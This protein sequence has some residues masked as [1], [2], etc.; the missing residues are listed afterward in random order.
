M[1]VVAAIMVA[2]GAR[3]DVPR[4][5][6]GVGQWKHEP[7]GTLTS[8]STA[9]D[10]TQGFP[11]TT[12]QEAYGHLGVRLGGP[13]WAPGELWAPMLRLRYTRIG[14]SGTSFQD[15]STYLGGVLITLDTTDRRTEADFTQFEGLLYFTVGDA[16]RAELGGGIKR[17]DGSIETRQ[18]RTTG[19]GATT[20]SESREIP[21]EFPVWYGGLY[22]QPAAW[23]SF[24]AEAT[25]SARANDDVRDYVAR[26]VLRP[27]TWMGVEG[28]YRILDMDVRDAAGTNYEFEFR[29]SYAGLNFFYGTPAAPVEPEPAPAPPPPPPADTDGDGVADGVDQCPRTP[30]GAAVDARGCPLDADGDTVPDGV[31]QCPDTPANTRVGPDGCALPAPAA[32]PPPDEDGDGVPDDLDRCP[33][34]LPG[35]KVNMSG[36]ATRAQATVLQGV[37][38]QLN[39]SYLMRDS[40]VLLMKVVEAL[41]AQPGLKVLIEGHTC[42]IGDAKY[43][44]WLSQRRANRV[45]EFLVRHGIPASRL[46]AQGFGEEKPVVPNDDERMRELNRRTVFRIIED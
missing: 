2:S 15:D 29:G 3:A 14:T 31:D 40:E 16:I 27:W 36:C 30:P 21:S 6:L 19:S 46:L 33:G 11:L 12:E 38:F 39:S 10:I 37:T 9:L 18:V 23:L 8:G 22:A 43:N 26:F 32:L 5:E 17:I 4:M 28:G 35:L 34:T 24:G 20:T 45:M 25:A 44:K 42:D 1:G 13:N 41:K 7:E